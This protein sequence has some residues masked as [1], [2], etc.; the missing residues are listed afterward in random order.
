MFF[1]DPP[2]RP[3]LLV[4]LLAVAVFAILSPC[5]RSGFFEHWDDG[6]HLLENPHVRSLAP[7]NIIRIFRSTVNSIYIPLTVFSFALEYHFFGFDPFVY[8]LNNLLLHLATALGVFFLARRLGFPFWAA[9]LG[10]LLWGIHPMRVESVAWITERKDVLYGFLYVAA[11]WVYADYI[12]SKRAVLFWVSVGLGCLSMLAKPMALSLPLILLLLDWYARRPWGYRV[13]MEK[14]AH[15]F[16]VVPLTWLTYSH[17]VRN[18]VRYL[19]QAFLTWIWTFI[20]YLRK[21]FIPLILVP[22]Y[23]IPQPV[24]LAHHEYGVAVLIFFLLLGLIWRF[25]SDRNLVF[26]FLFYAGSIFFLLRFDIREDYCFVADRFMY[27][28]SLGICL[29]LGGKIHAF[30]RRDGPLSFR[31]AG[32][33]ALG[34]LFAALGVKAYRQ[35]GLWNDGL[36]LW[37]HTISRN[38]QSYVGY[39][40]RGCIYSDQKKKDLALTEF[41]KATQLYPH[42]AKGWYDRGNILKELARWHEALAC[43]NKALNIEPDYVKVY[44]NRALVHRRLG[45]YNLAIRDFSTAIELQPDKAGTYFNRGLIYRELGFEDKAQADFQRARQAS[46]AKAEE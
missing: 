29:W 24:S 39:V 38:P 41:E 19:D 37:D 6:R 26:G 43:Y 5:L 21:F 31:A 22:D 15:L 42:V 11:L 34:L 46:H 2:N 3:G 17:F 4:I 35:A 14:A 28:P 10:G 8:H 16:Y 27:L 9:W 36:T 7:E 32:Y 18:P 1:A 44:N 30:M 23:Y 40:N 45:R 20:F 33:V 12:R 13:W 25:R